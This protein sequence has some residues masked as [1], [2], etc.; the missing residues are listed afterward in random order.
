MMGQAAEYA[1]S[2]RCVAL[3]YSI[4]LFG[5]CTVLLRKNKMRKGAIALLRWNSP[6][7]RMHAGP[8]VYNNAVIC[9]A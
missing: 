6:G 8:G 5:T 1:L 7:T 3:L 4:A 2:I 9:M